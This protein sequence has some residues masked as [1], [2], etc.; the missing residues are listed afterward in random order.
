MTIDHWWL[1][2]ESS[3]PQECNLWSRVC[4]KNMKGRRPNHIDRLYRNCFSYNMEF[5]EYHQLLCIIRLFLSLVTST[6]QVY[7]YVS[8]KYLVQFK[9]LYNCVTVW[10]KCFKYE[11]LNPVSQGWSC[12]VGASLHCKAC[13]LHTNE[14]SKWIFN[15]I[16]K[17]TKLL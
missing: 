13:T 5:L 9:Q 11:Q 12:R 16:L 15:S 2:T 17:H 8:C 4:L 10:N 3:W 6:G 14:S 1:S 7:I